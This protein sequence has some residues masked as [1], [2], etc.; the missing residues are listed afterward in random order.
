MVKRK[1]ETDLDE[2]LKWVPTI[3]RM[4][5]ISTTPIETEVVTNPTQIAEITPVS[6]EAGVATNW[7][8]GVPN[9]QEEDNEWFWVLLAQSGHE[10]WWPALQVPWSKVTGTVGLHNRG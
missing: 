8:V 5:N 6:V 2:W 3:E 10:R 9:D 4:E 1:A 7:L